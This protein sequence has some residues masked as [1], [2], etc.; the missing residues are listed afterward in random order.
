[1]L[2]SYTKMGAQENPF[3]FPLWACEVFPADTWNGFN[4]IQHLLLLGWRPQAAQ[5]NGI[6]HVTG[7]SFGVSLPPSPF[8][9]LI[10]LMFRRDTSDLKERH[11]IR[12]LN[13]SIK[14][15]NAW[16]W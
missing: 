10:N 2:V 12:Y 8:F 11:L 5:T 15:P 14:F 13:I 9:S 3:G 6:F 1:M 7:T 16:D 4:F